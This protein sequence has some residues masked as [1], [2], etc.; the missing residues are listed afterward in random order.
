MTA[1][2]A[3]L[4]ELNNV[5]GSLR[6]AQGWGTWDLLGGGLIATAIKHSRVNDA[7]KSVHRVQQ[8]LMIF[9]RELKDVDLNIKPGVS[10]DIGAFAAF[11]DYF[12]DGLIVDWVVQSR[13]KNSL[14][15]AVLQKDKVADVLGILKSALEKSQQELDRLKKEKQILVESI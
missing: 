11:A 5:I 7:K 9:L 15:N 14:A 12:F 10:I 4:A 3:V 13:I 8:K 6:S 1:G 2:N